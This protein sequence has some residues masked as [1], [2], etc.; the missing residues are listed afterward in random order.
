MAIATAMAA[1]VSS[2][3][4][5]PMLF[6]VRFILPPCVCVAYLFLF[7][8]NDVVMYNDVILQGYRKMNKST[9]R[10]SSPS[11]MKYTGSICLI[12]YGRRINPRLTIGCRWVTSSI[13]WRCS[14]FNGILIPASP[15][16]ND[17]PHRH[18]RPHVPLL[19]PPCS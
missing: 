15:V 9:C 14:C 5:D 17:S 10:C 16:Q 1:A 19:V 11:K 12:V 18:R 4:C 2:I 7:L 3:R 6:L 8:S 13:K